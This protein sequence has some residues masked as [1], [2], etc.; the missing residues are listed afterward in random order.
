VERRH[1]QGLRKLQFNEALKRVLD[2][3]ATDLIENT[4]SQVEA[5]GAQ[6]VDDLRRAPKRLAAFSAEVAAEDAALKRYLMTRVYSQPAIAEDR[7][8]S[9]AALDSLFNFFLENPDRLPGQNA[10]LARSEPPH[11]IVCDYIA[12]MT[13]HF[14]L[15]QCH[16]LL[17][18]PLAPERG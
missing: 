14:L 6:S 18:T 13:D 8:R 4:R 1:P 2:R 3:F 15:R 7:G 9:V 5:S 11:R 12:G 17:G 16:E 10:D